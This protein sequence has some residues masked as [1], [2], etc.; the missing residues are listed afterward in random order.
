MTCSKYPPMLSRFLDRE[1]SPQEAAEIE[2]HWSQCEDCRALKENWQLQSAFLRNHLGRHRLGDDFVKKVMQAVPV[3]PGGTGIPVRDGAGRRQLLRWLQAAA[4]VVMAA[5]V[6]SLYFSSR[7]SVG[8]ARVIDPGEL[9]V[10]QSSDWVRATVGELLHPGDWL[11]NPLQGA[12][13]IMWKDTCR[14]TLEAGTLAHIP[15]GQ[16]QTP[17]Q[18]VLIS[19]SLSSE[20]QGGGRDFQVSTPAGSVTSSIGRFTVRVTDRALPQLMVA[21]DGTETLTGTIVPIGEVRVGN[22]KAVVQAAQVTH[23]VLAGTTAVFSKSDFSSAVMPPNTVE[24]SLRVVSNTA[25]RGS[26]HASLNA[27]LESVW[28][29]VEASNISIRKLLEWATASKVRGGDDTIVA[30]HLRFP[31]H[32]SPESVAFAAGSALGLPISYRQEKGSQTI[33]VGHLNPMQAPD[34]V[35]GEFTFEK[36]PSGRISFDFRSVPAGQV[37]QILRSAVIPL[38][39]L[40]TE[41]A[42]MPVSIQAS[43][44]SPEETPSWIGKALGL[45]FRMADTMAGVIEIG[46]PGVTAPRSGATVPGL[47]RAPAPQVLP[48]GDLSAEETRPRADGF[49]VSSELSVSSTNVP[50]ALRMST[51]TSVARPLWSIIDPRAD[52]AG[53]YASSASAGGNQS[54][55]KGKTSPK[56]LQF[57][58]AAELLGKP[59]PSTHLIWPTLELEN[60]FGAEAAYLVTNSV[61]LAAHSVWYGYDQAG[62]LIAQYEIPVSGLSTLA[63]LP[64]RDLPT[65]L[66]AGGHWETF[67]NLA[68]VGSRESEFG[69]GI[70]WPAS[71][72]RLNH[73]WAFPSGW[74]NLGARLWLVNPNREPASVVLAIIKNGT[75]VATE[76][77]SLPPHAGT[78][79]PEVGSGIGAGMTVLVSVSEGIAATGIK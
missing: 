25:E 19:G 17:D 64:T 69:N 55:A 12:P 2:G 29:N 39:E 59:G 47:Q 56:K 46:S 79:W 58:G 3:Q 21:E 50:M 34:R 66:G 70:G 71:S 49:S 11:R 6:I 30:G 61:D 43:S 4:A 24:A 73:Q 23:E 62:Q 77:L 1:L 13:E 68:L 67:S 5:V 40:S 52:V 42:A 8:Y 32:S 14:F 41:T 44:L 37:F 57:F 38:P 75:A 16:A 65:F 18:V 51:Q 27:T 7:N 28:I 9:E 33:A 74:L 31:A 48:I 53:F 22:G 78:I 15:D 35:P 63:L 36:S 26:I 76:L 10:L 54:A 45:E 72:E 20:V 60:A